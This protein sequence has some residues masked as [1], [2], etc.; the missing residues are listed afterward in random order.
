MADDNEPSPDGTMGEVLLAI[1]ALDRERTDFRA[2][3]ARQKRRADLA[4]AA[5]DRLDDL[6]TERYTADDK[7]RTASMETLDLLE[8][9]WAALNR[10]RTEVQGG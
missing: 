10:G 8:D 1:A 7:Y 4:E 9:L 6:I 2:T 5:F 3:A